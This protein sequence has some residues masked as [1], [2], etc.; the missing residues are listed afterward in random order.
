MYMYKMK[1]RNI[2][3]LFRIDRNFT[4]RSQDKMLINSRF[5]YLYL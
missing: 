2:I 3:Y 1:I 4:V 5:N